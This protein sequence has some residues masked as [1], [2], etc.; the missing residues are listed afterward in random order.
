[1]IVSPSGP[2]DNRLVPHVGFTDR[3]RTRQRL[4]DSDGGVR[5]QVRAVRRFFENP[6]PGLSRPIQG[7][8]E[9]I[10]FGR[11]NN[12]SYSN[13]TSGQVGIV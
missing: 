9:S 5:P 1:M 6:H 11:V 10:R 13:R 4:Q 7:M 3:E 2:W 12:P 8:K